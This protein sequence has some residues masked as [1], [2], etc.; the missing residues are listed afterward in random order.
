MAEVGRNIRTG[1]FIFNNYHVLNVTE[2]FDDILFKHTDGAAHVCLG[3]PVSVN[4]EEKLRKHKESNQCRVFGS[5]IRESIQSNRFFSVRCFDITDNTP[6][7]PN[8]TGSCRTFVTLQSPREEPKSSVHA[9]FLN[10]S[11]SYST[12]G[13]RV[14]P[15]YRS[16]TAYYDILQV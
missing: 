7:F 13:T 12:N 6:I 8:Y 14:T 11:H 4:S 3:E 9:V 10:R 5:F 1:G 16:K 15:V 2:C